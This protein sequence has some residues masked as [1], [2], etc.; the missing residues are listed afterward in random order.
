MARQQVAIGPRPLRPGAE[1]VERPGAVAFASPQGIS[2]E[3][4]R[5]RLEVE[6]I[7]AGDVAIFVIMAERL[8][9]IAL[10]MLHVEARD[11]ERIAGPVERRRAAQH[12]PAAAVQEAADDLEPGIV[13]G[14]GRIAAGVEIGEAAGALE[15]FAVARRREA[16]HV[17]GGETLAIVL[18]VHL[19]REFAIIHALPRDR[20]VDRCGRRYIGGH[21]LRRSAG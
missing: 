3:A 9:V 10:A 6:R 11:V 17:E 12:R 8:G 7:V 14:R 20:H 1:I 13:I 15:Q 18:P 5:G 2:V 4:E 16:H 21:G 19:D